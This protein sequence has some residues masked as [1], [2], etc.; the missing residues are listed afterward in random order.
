MHTGI[1]H[2]SLFLYLYL[3]LS[4]YLYLSHYLTSV[5]SCPPG[6]G[7]HWEAIAVYTLTAAIAKKGVGKGERE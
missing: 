1:M 6:N 2:L 4:I 5:A 3:S 7:W